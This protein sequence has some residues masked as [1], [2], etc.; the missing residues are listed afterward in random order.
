MEDS[1]YRI[2]VKALIKDEQGRYLLIR[3]TDEGW[4]LPGGG[5]DHGETPQEALS[6]ELSEELGVNVI[7]TD[8]SPVYVSSDL[9]RHGK[10]AG[11]WRLWLV[12]GAEVEIDQIVIGDNVDALDWAFIDIGSLSEANI[13]PT[14]Y[15]LFRELQD[16]KL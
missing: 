1:L 14:E 6:R 7:I 4:E 11:M 9:T 15:K 16:I 13:D 2:S 3:T 5:M 10:R 8:Q 12:Y